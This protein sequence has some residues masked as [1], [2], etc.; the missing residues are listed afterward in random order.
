MVQCSLKTALI[1][2]DLLAKD[3]GQTTTLAGV[4][5][6]KAT[7]MSH[8]LK[9]TLDLAKDKAEELDLVQV[10]IDIQDWVNLHPWKAAFYAAS[11]IG[12]FAPEILSTP[13]LEALGFGVEGVQA[14]SIAAKIQSVIGPVAARCVLTI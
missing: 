14:G 11:A 3:D 6:E 12:L 8:L 10:A 2:K 1:E 4:T 5:A 13:A 7:T 9:K